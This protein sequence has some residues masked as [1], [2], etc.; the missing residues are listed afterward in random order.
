LLRSLTSTISE[1]DQFSFENKN[2]SKR[3]PNNRNCFLFN[4]N[5]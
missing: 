5:D 4:L 1:M 3:K 2:H